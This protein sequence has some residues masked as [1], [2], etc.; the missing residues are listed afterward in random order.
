MFLI[1]YAIMYHSLKLTYVTEHAEIQAIEE[2]RAYLHE[3]LTSTFMCKI[4]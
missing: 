2:T 3:D 4:F 1:W